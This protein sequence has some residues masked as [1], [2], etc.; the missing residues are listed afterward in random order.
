MR[1]VI[2]FVRRG[3]NLPPAVCKTCPQYQRFFNRR[4]QDLQDGLE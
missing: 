4:L 3:G 2:E 1:D